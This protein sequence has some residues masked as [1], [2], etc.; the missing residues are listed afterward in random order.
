MPGDIA[1][2]NKTVSISKRALR[3][4]L[5][6]MSML[7]VSTPVILK[8]VW[9]RWMILAAIVFVRINQNVAKVVHDAAVLRQDDGCRVHF[10]HNCGP[11]QD[12]A[13]RKLA[14]LIHGGCKLF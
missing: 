8:G 5:S 2:R 9:L 14:A 3:R 12:V 10:H 7:T 6:M 11:V 4:A 13:R 1:V